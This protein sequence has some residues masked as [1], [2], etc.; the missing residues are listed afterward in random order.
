MH[1]SAGGGWIQLPDWRWFRSSGRKASV[2]SEPRLVATVASFISVE[3][4]ASMRCGRDNGEHEA[5]VN[6]AGRRG[7]GRFPSVERG[8][9]DVA[10]YADVGGGGQSLDSRIAGRPRGRDRFGGWVA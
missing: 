6:S 3:R 8:G 4:Q 1:C 10:R 5:P 2:D 9:S 7:G